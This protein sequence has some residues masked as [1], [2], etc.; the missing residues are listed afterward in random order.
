MRVGVRRLERERLR[1]GPDLLL[2]ARLQLGDARLVLEK[3]P[4]QK[5]DVLAIDAFSSDSIPVHLLTREAMATYRRHLAEGGVIAFHI[6]NRYFD[7][8][9][10]LARLAKELGLVAYIRNDTIEDLE[11]Q[12]RDSLWVLL[13]RNKA[14]EPDADVD[15]IEEQLESLLVDLDSYLAT[16]QEQQR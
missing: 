12:K 8:S 6:S 13:A 15:E 11:E 2:A 5:L 10:V 3:E 16:V 1:V 14:D 7:L 9:P 4:D